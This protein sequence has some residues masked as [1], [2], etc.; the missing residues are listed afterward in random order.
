MTRW[1]VSSFPGA[2]AISCASFALGLA[3]GGPRAALIAA[4]TTTLLFWIFWIFWLPS[5]A[6]ASWLARIRLADPAPLARS[7][8]RAFDGRP[9]PALV[10]RLL[11]W[12]TP[13]PVLMAWR[14][15]GARGVLL[16][17]EG[18]LA[19]RG[20][21]SFREACRLAVERLRAPAISVETAAAFVI[22][23]GCRHLPPAFVAVLFSPSAASRDEVAAT[24]GLSPLSLA[25]ASIWMF[26]LSWIQRVAA[27]R[28]MAGT[29]GFEPGLEVC[30]QWLS[31]GVD[32]RHPAA[33]PPS[34]K[35]ILSWLPRRC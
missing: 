26:W 34:P 14:L 15:R 23:W 6:A 22:A 18:W 29:G 12:S 32:G 35:S 3:A 30:V 19:E 20:E 7:W 5:H 1:W 4:S 27:D 9:G 24:P 21:T 31:F 25:K 17:S 11:L 2:L 28:S 10:P 13:V 16:V 8:E 33:M